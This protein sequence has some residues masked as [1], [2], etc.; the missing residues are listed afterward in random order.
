[1]N[2]HKLTAAIFCTVSIRLFL[3]GGFATAIV[4]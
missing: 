1:M 2:D 3:R 4:D